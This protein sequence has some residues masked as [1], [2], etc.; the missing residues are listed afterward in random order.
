MFGFGA[1]HSAC[2]QPH[3]RDESSLVKSKRPATFGRPATR[4]W[5]TLC[6]CKLSLAQGWNMGWWGTAGDVSKES[7]GK[8]PAFVLNNLS[9]RGLRKL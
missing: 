8:L 3:D 9:L 7:L 2:F 4:M 5:N 6:V 1:C